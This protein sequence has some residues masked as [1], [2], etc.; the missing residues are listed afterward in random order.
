MRLRAS[1]KALSHGGLEVLELKNHAL[2]F[3]RAHEDAL[4]HRERIQ[5]LVNT[6]YRDELLGSAISGE[7]LDIHHKPAQLDSRVPAR[8]LYFR[9]DK[10]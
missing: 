8:G 1:S 9:V 3:E 2:L 4:G 5:V 10:P 6:G 7:W